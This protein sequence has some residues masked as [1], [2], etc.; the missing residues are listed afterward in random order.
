MGM[1]LF[2]L[3]W[4]EL[5]GVLVFGSLVRTKGQPILAF[6]LFEPQPNGSPFDLHLAQREKGYPQEETHPSMDAF[7]RWRKGG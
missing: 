3:S 2:F 1:A 5:R 4:G 7:G 6:Q